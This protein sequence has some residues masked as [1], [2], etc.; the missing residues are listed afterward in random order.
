M[1]SWAQPRVSMPSC[2]QRKPSHHISSASSWFSLGRRSSRRGAVQGDMVWFGLSNG[3]KAKPAPTGS[4]SGSHG[5]RSCTATGQHWRPNSLLPGP[6]RTPTI[7]LTPFTCRG[8]GFESRQLDKGLWHF[9]L[10][11]GG[12]SEDNGSDR[13]GRPSNQP[14]RR[15]RKRAPGPHRKLTTVSASRN[16]AHDSVELVLGVRI[17]HFSV[18]SLAGEHLQ[19]SKRQHEH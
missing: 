3:E 9:D 16:Q 8:H 18:P 19:V 1:F 6:V 7:Q 13:G 14:Q 17:S 5:N 4:R 11:S 10:H 15:Q 2:W 12:L